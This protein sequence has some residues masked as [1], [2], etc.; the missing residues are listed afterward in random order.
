VKL[1]PES[2]Q[3]RLAIGIVSVIV[4]M[5]LIAIGVDALVPSPEGTR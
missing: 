2:R 5:N 4:A 3:A 1:L